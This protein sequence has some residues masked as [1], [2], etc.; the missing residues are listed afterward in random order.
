[1]CLLCCVRIPPDLLG[2][3]ESHFPRVAAPRSIMPPPRGSAQTLT[4][5]PASSHC[6][7][8]CLL[9]A[10]RSR[11]C[12]EC[13]TWLRA[14]IGGRRG[15]ARHCPERT[16]GRKSGPVIQARKW[17]RPRFGGNARG[18]AIHRRRIFPSSAVR[19]AFACNNAGAKGDRPR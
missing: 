18:I 5:S 7:L 6:F 10:H 1:M 15:V 4:P 12:D 19:A 17:A 8:H 9:S 14:P 16:G 2:L 3:Q 13:A 11:V